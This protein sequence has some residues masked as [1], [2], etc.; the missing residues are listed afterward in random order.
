MKNIIRNIEILLRPSYW[1]QNYKFSKE[2]DKSLNYL[3][4]KYEFT[5]ID[6]CT[7]R[8]G[9]TKIWIANHPYASFRIDEFPIKNLRPSRKTILRAYKKLNR[10]MDPII[11][12]KLKNLPQSDI[13]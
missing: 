6:E 4:D 9:S 13:Y 1:S 5:N 8:L 3:L 2:V 12:I 10:K 11:K 7:A